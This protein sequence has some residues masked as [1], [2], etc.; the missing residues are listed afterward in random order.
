LIGGYAMDFL[1]WNS[2][3]LLTYF[4]IFSN[5]I[6]SFI[7]LFILR[8]SISGMNDHSTGRIFNWVL[9]THVIYFILDI[10]WAPLNFGLAENR[11]FLQ[12]IRV[13]KYW[14][15][16]ISAYLWFQYISYKIN[17][18]II[19]TKLKHMFS[20]MLN[21]ISFIVAVIIVVNNDMSSSGTLAI[22][23]GYLI[24]LVP[25]IYIVGAILNCLVES[26]N[27]PRNMRK[28]MFLLTGYTVI[29][30]L[31]GGF[32]ILFSQIPC[33]CF[34]TA[35]VMLVMY[36]IDLQGLI[37]NDPLTTISNRN[38]LNKYYEDNI[39]SLDSATII[40]LDVDKFKHINDKFGHLEGDR[41]LK[42][43]AKCLKKVAESVKD[44]FVARYGGDEFVIILKTSTEEEVK[45]FLG[46]LDREISQIKIRSNYN[47]SLS[48]GYTFK[49]H[50]DKFDNVIRRADKELYLSKGKD[51]I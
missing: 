13:L 19:D 20:Y 34:G 11:I 31:S 8:R 22:V 44:S 47:V 23:L 29:L 14:N 18:V 15:I 17:H 30:L 39:K 50:D 3:Q 46:L 32:Q 28:S 25:F 37:Y 33:L 21:I 24:N 51:V 27:S 42:N 10:I 41:A 4:Y 1:T 9:I 40:I 26:F 7:F 38:G 5:V 43:V 49:K 45:H 16:T 48:Y 6:C 35:F 36:T 12:I 2:N